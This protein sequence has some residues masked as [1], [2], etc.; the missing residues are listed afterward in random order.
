MIEWY[1]FGG[2]CPGADDSTPSQNRQVMSDT[3]TGQIIT[4]IVVILFIVGFLIREYIGGQVQLDP[5][6][7]AVAGQQE[8]LQQLQALIPQVNDNGGPQPDRAEIEAIVAGLVAGIPADT[9]EAQIA[10]FLTQPILGHAQTQAQ[11]AREEDHVPFAME[12]Y[13]EQDED[14]EDYDDEQEEQDEGEE[15]RQARWFDEVDG[16]GEYGVDGFGDY[17]TAESSSRRR[18]QQMHQQFDD[19]AR[20]RGRA[21][22]AARRDERRA[23]ASGSG[24]PNP[25]DGSD[26][27][28]EGATDEDLPD[29][30][31]VPPAPLPPALLALP[32][33]EQLA[34][35]GWL[36]GDEVQIGGDGLGLGL[37][38]NDPAED[39]GF[40][41]DEDF[42]G[43]LE[44]IGMRGSPLTLI[45]NLG[46][47]SS[48]FFEEWRHWI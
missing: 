18:I 10:A 19:E 9:L 2:G 44:A 8:A 47:F 11:Q 22:R 33:N 41:L 36:R 4:S 17:G 37:G 5:P 46:E 21:L 27:D 13:E 14:Y 42:D 34:V 26:G 25:D 31:A 16:G 6:P 39:E 29:L 3:F 20:V 7:P 35:Q 40:L 12:D 38:G 30:E 1:A 28:S 23:Q 45:Q 43:V 32:R 15:G 24:G 48:F